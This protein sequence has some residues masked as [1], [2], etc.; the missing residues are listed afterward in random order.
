MYRVYHILLVIILVNWRLRPWLLLLHF[1]VST[2]GRPPSAPSGSPVSHPTLSHLS[3]SHQLYE[4]KNPAC[5]AFIVSPQK[6]HIVCLARSRPTVNSGE[7]LGY[8]LG[9]GHCAKQ[10]PVLSQHPPCADVQFIDCT[11]AT[12]Y[13]IDVVFVPILL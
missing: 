2:S 10:W 11:K 8:L 12:G 3:S 9:A 4:D 13:D 7:C 5:P 6:P 1:P